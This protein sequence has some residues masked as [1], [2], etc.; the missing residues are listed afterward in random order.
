MRVFQRYYIIM[1]IYIYIEIVYKLDLLV[2]NN[3]V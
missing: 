1:F 3:M 2:C